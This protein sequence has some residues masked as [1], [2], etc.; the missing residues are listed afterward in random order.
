MDISVTKRDGRKEPLLWEKVNRQLVWAAEGLDVSVS[1]VELKAKVKLVDG[2]KTSDI[3]KELVKTAADL[4]SEK[5][6]DY[7]YM[8]ARLAIFDVRKKVFGA[9]NPP[10]LLQFVRHMVA[11]GLYDEHL[12]EDYSKAELHALDKFIDHD[13]DMDF[14]YAGVKQLIG[15]YLVQNRVTGELHE[16]PQF[17]YM[18]IG[19]ALFAN[20]PRDTRLQY[21]REFYDA[22]SEFEIS[23]PTPIMG[24]VRTPTRQFSSC[25]KIECGDSLDSI[26]ASASSII[27]YISQRA[28]IGIN[29][30]RIRALGSEIRGGEA[31]HTGVIPF[32]KHF[33]SAVKSCSQGALR[34]G[35]A[36][37]F[38]P[39]WHYEFESMIVL[40]NNRG[41]EENRVR[42]LDYGIQLNKL[43]YQRL[44]QGGNITLFSPHEV[45]GMYDAFFNDQELFEKLYIEAE[46]NPNI[47]KKT[48]KAIDAFGMLMQERAGTGRI[49]IQHV[50]HCNVNGPFK[51][52]LAPV[53]QSNLCV[54]PETQI[55][56]K[57]G[58]QQISELEGQDVDVWN[59][60]EWSSTKV[61]KTGSNQKLLKVET[62][63]GQTI[64]CTEYHKWYVV[65]GYGKDPIVKRTHEL[66]P[67]DKLI[68]FDLPVIDGNLVMNRAYENGFYSADGCKS[69]N[70]QLIY[71]YGNKKSLL[72]KF[73]YRSKTVNLEHDRITLRTGGLHEKFVVPCGNHSVESKLQWLAGWLD[74]DGT[75]G[76]NGTNESLSGTSIHKEFLLEIQQML[77]TLGVSAKVRI[78]SGSD[79][80]RMLPLND[81]TGKLGEYEC[82][83]VWRLLISS[84]DTQRLIQLGLNGYM[85]RLHVNHRKPQRD[86]KQFNVVDAI[87]DEGRFDDTYCFNEPK[88]HMGMFNGILTGQCMEITLPTQPLED[89]NDENGEIALCTLSAFNLGKIKST[90]DFERLS[91]IAVRALDALLDYQNYP[92]KAAEISTMNRRSLG[93]GVIN[94]A[95][96]LAKNGVKYSDGSANEL[97]HEYMEAM[98]FYLI[99]A[100]MELAKEKGAC[101][102]FHET[103]YADG[104]M[105]IDR[106][107]NDV[108]GVAAPVYKMDWDWLRK[109][110]MTHGIRNSTLSCAMPSETSS[111]VS[112]ATN[113]IE[114]PRGFVSVKQSKD[115]VLK[116]VVPELDKYKGQYELLWDIPNNKGYIDLVAIMQKFMD[117]SLSANTNYVPANYPNN[118]VPMKLLL[119]DLA[120]TYKMGLKTLYYHNTNDGSGD[121]VMEDSSECSSCKI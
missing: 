36:T 121:A 73:E 51:A 85:G 108:D 102:K 82:Q 95:Y 31:V 47:R 20:Y 24:G 83:P 26:N 86:A 112:N 74:G 90:K 1:E 41:V 93:I 75:V 12:M 29:A 11:E 33:Q 22:V 104:R 40:K 71:L 8:A 98:Q 7:Q 44:V 15:K 4:I 3:H 34:G 69:F 116:Q 61:L 114:P 55:L 30:G 14:A 64:E 76:R 38:Y 59:G 115:G 57:S 50:D 42:H 113:G 66:K 96:F 62:S 25:V 87:I 118:K 45:E 5:Y 106:Y 80:I 72:D 65:E 53:R 19:M 46:N 119:K 10:T 39:M 105:P 60:E 6:P 17:L 23:L 101:P 103:E 99:K 109:E 111:Q 27:K 110:V 89:I 79:G 63:A 16:T 117:Q 18:A 37:L 49:Y 100:S 120:Y 21:V 107:K 28:G 70:T 48:I 52:D 84:I 54:A 67:G 78:I 32:F 94:F 2:M 77:Q 68:K 97:V 58:Y 81:G 56:T 91:V 35:A 9:F 13:R 88:R 43:M 92:I